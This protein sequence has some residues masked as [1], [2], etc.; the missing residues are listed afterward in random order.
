[1]FFVFLFFA[2]KNVFQCKAVVWIIKN[3]RCLNIKLN[4]SV[5][6][7]I[8]SIYV[9][10]VFKNEPL[11]SPNCQVRSQLGV[12]KDTNATD[13][14][15]LKSTIGSD[16]PLQHYQHKQLTS[17]STAADK[18]AQDFSQLRF[19]WSL[20]ASIHYPQGSSLQPLWRWQSMPLSCALNKHSKWPPSLF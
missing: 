7:L 20:N 2:F 6:I 5:I 1:M 14:N 19:N 3:Y 9:W 17:Q 4:T 18:Q 15:W 11:K 10:S 16:T 8:I 12:P 13:S